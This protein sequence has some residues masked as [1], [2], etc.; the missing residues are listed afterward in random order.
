[1]SVDA[2]FRI[3]DCLRIMIF[4]TEIK[5][6]MVFWFLRGAVTVKI[7]LNHNRTP[8]IKFVL[9]KMRRF[10]VDLKKPAEDHK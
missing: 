6:K 5:K 2:C 8:S 10:K 7:I 9:I 4:K 1:M 3:K